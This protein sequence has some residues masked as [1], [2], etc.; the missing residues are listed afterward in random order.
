MA[1]RT[2]CRAGK[3]FMSNFRYNSSRRFLFLFGIDT[4]CKK[5]YTERNDR[6]NK[7]GAMI[8]EGAFHNKGKLI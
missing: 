6:N 2:G 1:A 3:L 5:K 8:S 4:G 7:F